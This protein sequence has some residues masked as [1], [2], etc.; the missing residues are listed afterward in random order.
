MSSVTTVMN[1]STQAAA[2]AMAERPAAV[3]RALLFDMD[4]TLAETEALGHRIAYNR[5]FREMGLRI[6]WTPELYRQLL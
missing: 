5:T 4:G 6:S 2:T 1:G 3:L